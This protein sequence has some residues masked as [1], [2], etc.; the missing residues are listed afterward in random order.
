VFYLGCN[1]ISLNVSI[2]RRFPLC[3]FLLLLDDVFSLSYGNE[4][5]I[6]LVDR[7]EKNTLH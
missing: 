3:F 4:N 2:R 7:V 6:P 1:Y 5:S